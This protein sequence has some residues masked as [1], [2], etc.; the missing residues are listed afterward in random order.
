MLISN[1]VLSDHLPQLT[2]FV[3]F[4]S[5]SDW[6]KLCMDTSL[7]LIFIHPLVSHALAHMLPGCHDAISSSV[8]VCSSIN[9][10]CES[11][12]IWQYFSLDICMYHLMFII[13]YYWQSFFLHFI[14]MIVCHSFPVY[15]VV[16]TIAMFAWYRS[17]L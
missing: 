2:E 5:E 15:I 11:M 10:T 6:R 1:C 3:N 4:C 8:H 13:I 14:Y 16:S 12:Y 17:T 9:G 7:L